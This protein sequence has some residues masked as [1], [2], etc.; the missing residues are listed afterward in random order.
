MIIQRILVVGDDIDPYN[1]K[2]MMRAYCTRC[3]PNMDAWFFEDVLG[4]PLVP[5]IHAGPVNADRGGKSVSIACFRFNTQQDRIGKLQ[6]SSML[7]QRRLS[8]KYLQTGRQW[9]WGV[10]SNMPT[11]FFKKYGHHYIFSI[12]VLEFDRPYGIEHC[13]VSA[14]S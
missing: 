2:D 12:V 5:Y 4:F 11:F 8:R 9:N 10:N 3:C 14:A 1:F 13:F 7:T 6:I